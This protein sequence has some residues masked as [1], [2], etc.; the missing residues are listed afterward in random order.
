MLP[1]P[2]HN[3]MRLSL[4]FL[5]FPYEDILYTRNIKSQAHPPKSS[6]GGRHIPAPPTLRLCPWLAGGLRLL[7][8]G[9]ERVLHVGRHVQLQREGE[10]GVHLLQGCITF[11]VPPWSLSSLLGKN[12]KLLRGEGPGVSRLWGKIQCGKKG[13]GKQYHIPYNIMVVWKNIKWG[14]GRKNLERKSR[15]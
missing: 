5:I 11:R 4:N 13:K 12:I 14:R 15:F 2:P 10:V 8:G 3:K 9:D 7:L 1:P 6:G